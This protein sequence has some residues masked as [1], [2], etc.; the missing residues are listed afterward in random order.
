MHLEAGCSCS[1]CTLNQVADAPGATCFNQSPITLRARSR[2]RALVRVRCNLH[3]VHLKKLQP[4]SGCTWSSCNLIQQ[5]FATHFRWFPKHVSFCNIYLLSE[6]VPRSSC[7]KQLH[8][9]CADTTGILNSWYR[10]LTVLTTVGADELC[11]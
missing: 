9:A 11:T 8:E 1:R 6:A 5:A 4:A 7:T 2:D 10:L 3:Q